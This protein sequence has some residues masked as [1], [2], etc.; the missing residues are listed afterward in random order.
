MSNE[1]RNEN[2]PGSTQTRS[3][4]AC[5]ANKDELEREQRQLANEKLKIEIKKLAS[6][7]APEKWW[8]KLA[9]NVVAVGGILTVAATGYG[10]FDGY[11]K[12][13][14][15]RERTRSTELRMQFEEAIKKLESKSAISK[16]VA[17][18]VLSGYLTESYRSFHRQ[19]LF[20]FASVVATESDLQTQA[21]IL[22]L[23]NAQ[24]AKA[25]A[26]DDWT[27][28]QIMLVS[29]SRALVARRDLYRKRQ[30][31]LDTIIP[32]DDEVAARHVGN[33]IAVNIRRGVV[34]AFGAY[35][36]I[37][38]EACDLRYKRFPDGADF[39]G[40]ILDRADFRGATLRRAVFDNAEMEGTVFA[41]A[42]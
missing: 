29:Q 15:D 36:G 38:C 42:Y 9:K 40:A 35:A 31:G 4:A 24:D 14:N 13:L 6:D 34:P 25:I 7:T 32:T 16:L 19:I 39:T 17:V 22:D 27:Y 30:F 20:T 10:L 23:M 5:T 28:F 41:Q 3:V 1:L 26:A 8:S 11:S 37:Y 12:T 21:A 18:S 33:L 2:E